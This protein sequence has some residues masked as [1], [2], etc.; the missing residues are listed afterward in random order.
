MAISILNNSKIKENRDGVQAKSIEDVKKTARKVTTVVKNKPKPVPEEPKT[1][2]VRTPPSLTQT[3][4]TINNNMIK[5]KYLNDSSVVYK[6]SG[7]VKDL[8]GEEN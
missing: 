3:A 7:Y 5:P 8:L 2:P 6:K 4:P 1:K